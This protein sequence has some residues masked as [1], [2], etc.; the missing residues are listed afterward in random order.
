MDKYLLAY[1]KQRM[2]EMGIRRYHFEPLRFILTAKQPIAVRAYNEFY[3]LTGI[4]LVQ[5]VQII[6]DTNIV[7]GDA[8]RPATSIVYMFYPIQEFSGLIEMRDSGSLSS[9]APIP[10]E[11]IRVVPTCREKFYVE[12][13]CCFPKEKFSSEPKLKK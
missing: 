5:G 3:Y 4:P 7:T 9:N 13:K 12:R 8:P 11:F 2:K 10:V 1:I 6:S